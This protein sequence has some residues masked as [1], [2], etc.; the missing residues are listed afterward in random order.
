MHSL[1]KVA[2]IAVVTIG[3]H[4]CLAVGAS[5][6][7]SGSLPI[8]QEK[9]SQLQVG[10]TTYDQAI[11][12][13]GL[14]LSVDSCCG[15]AWIA[16]WEHATSGGVGVSVPLVGGQGDTSLS[17]HLELYFNPKTKV[18]TRIE[19]YQTRRSRGGVNI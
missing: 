12:L 17:N 11:Q 18:L 8:E 2:C 5:G 1:I 14:P 10:K 7:K 4:G 6:E 16:K 19:Q 13:L 9:V 3:L 15:N